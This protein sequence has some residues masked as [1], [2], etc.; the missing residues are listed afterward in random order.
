M[1]SRRL[2]RFGLLIAGCTLVSSCYVATHYDGWRYQGG[3][4][5]NNG[6][7]SRPR[8]EAPLPTVPF[9]VPGR[10][11]FSFSRFPA[12]D[13]Y[14]ML[15]TPSA[16]A[17]SSIEKLTTEVRIRVIDQN[18]Q[19]NCDAIGS[20]GGN[21][22][23]QLIVTSSTGVLGLWHPGCA[24]LQL[25]ACAPCRVEIAVGPVDPATPALLLTPTLRGGGFELP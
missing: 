15:V 5:V 12:D 8:F 13:A 10:Y 22:T 20:P 7:F 14:V 25:R 1:I 11:E 3:R 19:I 23:Q 4:L 2:R 9:N 24:A 6:L 21:G 16:P 18:D 17:V